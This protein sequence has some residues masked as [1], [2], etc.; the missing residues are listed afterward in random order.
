VVTV[1]DTLCDATPLT[2]VLSSP[3]K[4]LTTELRDLETLYPTLSEETGSNSG[5]M[6]GVA[7]PSV[8]DEDRS[9][10][11]E[12]QGKTS[13]SPTPTPDSG[14]AVSGELPISDI[15]EDADAEDSGDASQA[16]DADAVGSSSPSDS[17]ESP[18][19]SELEAQQA[20]RALLITKAKVSRVLRDQRRAQRTTRR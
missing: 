10:V 11:A 5:D 7:D 14:A 13:P 9:G 17:S 6:T 20:A 8:S 12:D 15:N 1:T 18:S 19:E 3:A 16:D 2:H 4:V